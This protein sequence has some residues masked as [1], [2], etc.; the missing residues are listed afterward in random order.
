MKRVFVHFLDHIMQWTMPNTEVNWPNATLPTKWIVWQVWHCYRKCSGKNRFSKQ[1]WHERF[2]SIQLHSTHDVLE[3]V[4]TNNRLLFNSLRER[5]ATCL[6]S[7]KTARKP[8]KTAG[9]K[10]AMANSQITGCVPYDSLI[11]LW[12]ETNIVSE[13]YHQYNRW[14]TQNPTFQHCNI[15]MSSILSYNNYANEHETSSF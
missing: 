7:S 9:H 14:Y 6:V 8:T 3:L 11:S 15:L 4:L 10:T 12:A 13:A 1:A 5:C 2:A